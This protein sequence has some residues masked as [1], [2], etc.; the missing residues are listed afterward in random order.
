MSKDIIKD[1]FEKHAREIKLQ[2]GS[3]LPLLD[4]MSFKE[5]IKEYEKLKGEYNAKNSKS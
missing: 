1:A 4:S 5:A 3:K 2:G